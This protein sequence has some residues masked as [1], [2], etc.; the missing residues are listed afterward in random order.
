MKYSFA[1][2]VSGRTD[3]ADRAEQHLHRLCRK[4][5]GE[6]RYEIDVVD[7]TEDPERAER[8]RVIATP[9]VIRLVPLPRRR[10]IGDL[11][12]DDRVARALALPDPVAGVD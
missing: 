4:H 10:V 11:A 8:A 3:R 9:T 12:E 1:L 7:V 5:L 2:F 6:D